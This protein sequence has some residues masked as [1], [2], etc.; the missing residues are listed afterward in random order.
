M[1]AWRAAKYG[2]HSGREMLWEQEK[3]AELCST[4]SSVLA[5]SMHVYDSISIVKNSCS[6]SCSVVCL[7]FGGG[8]GSQ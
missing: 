1:L 7:S 8:G 6:Q 5:A 2:E 3:I 4:L